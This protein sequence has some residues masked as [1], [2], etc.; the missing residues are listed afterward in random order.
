MQILNPPPTPIVPPTTTNTI[1]TPSSP[2]LPE[3]GTS[4]PPLSPPPSTHE[5]PPNHHMHTRSRSGIVKPIDRLNLHSSSLSYI[6]RSH[7]MALKDPN[8]HKAMNEE[9]NAL[10][11]NGTWVLVLRPPGVN[12]VRSLWLF[13]QKFNVDG[14][15]S[16]YKARLVANG[17]SQQQGVDCDETFS[18][19]SNRYY[20]Y[21]SQSGYFQALAHSSS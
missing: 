18:P 6:P 12:V 7:I 14:Y 2:H 11:T 10:I 17:R 3:D 13:K 21:C 9:Y 16:L 5:G 1:N 20:P 19:V 8:W 4:S 15:L